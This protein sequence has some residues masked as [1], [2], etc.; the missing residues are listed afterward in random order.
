MNDTNQHFTSSPP[1]KRWVVNLPNPPLA[2][3][4]TGNLFWLIAEMAGRSK[5]RQRHSSGKIYRTLPELAWLVPAYIL[6]AES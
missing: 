4:A 2:R 5:E 1:R 3:R 6:S